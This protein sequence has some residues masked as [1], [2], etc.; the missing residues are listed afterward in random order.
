MKNILPH[1]FLMAALLFAGCNS[2]DCKQT[3]IKEVEH[4]NKRIGGQDELLKQLYESEIRKLE[5]ENEGLKRDIVR[6]DSIIDRCVELSLMF[7][8]TK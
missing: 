7:L 1:L 5:I 4:I 3:T 6:K 2:D 8:E